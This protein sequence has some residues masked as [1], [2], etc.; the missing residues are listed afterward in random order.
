MCIL[1]SILLIFCDSVNR[2]SQKQ[3]FRSQRAREMNTETKQL[4]SGEIELYGDQEFL[5]P[6]L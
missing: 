5:L 3:E 4:A 1:V 6:K 2:A